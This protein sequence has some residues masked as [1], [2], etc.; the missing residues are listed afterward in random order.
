MNASWPDQMRR[1]L[2]EL[3]VLTVLSQEEN[4]GYRILTRLEQ[5][6]VL[7]FS[8]STLYPMLSKMTAAGLL[9]VRDGPSERGK[10]RK[11]YRLTHQGQGRLMDLMGHWNA[12]HSAIESLSHDTDG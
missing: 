12:I 9:V 6:G 1:G 8:E 10:P 11:Y 7:T 3:C 5:T 2:A 4:Y